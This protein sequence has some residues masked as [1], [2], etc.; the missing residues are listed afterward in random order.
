MKCTIYQLITVTLAMILVNSEKSLS[1]FQQ[2][3]NIVIIRLR[4]FTQIQIFEGQF[5]ETENQTGILLLYS[6]ETIIV[7]VTDVCNPQ[8]TYNRTRYRTVL[9]NIHKLT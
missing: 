4:I 3:R 1:K 8:S 6:S 5:T 9:S 7:H 2:L